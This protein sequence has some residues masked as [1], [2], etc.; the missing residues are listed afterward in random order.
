MFAAPILEYGRVQ[1]SRDRL[2]PAFGPNDGAHAT[3][4]VLR[5]RPFDVIP[6]DFYLYV[7]RAKRI[8]DR[9]FV[10]DLLWS[11]N[12]SAPR[13]VASVPFQAALGY[14]AY[15]TKGEPAVYAAFLAAL[16]FLSW[17][18]SALI[19][20]ANSHRD[21]N[22]TGLLLASLLAFI[23]QR[24]SVIA[25]LFRSLWETIVTGSFLTGPIWQGYNIWPY[26][27]V[28]RFST[29]AWSL[30]LLLAVNATAG[31]VVIAPA[32][33]K[34]L[35]TLFGCLVL[36]ALGDSWSL[37]MATVVVGLAAGFAALRA[38]ARAKGL[39][40]RLHASVMESRAGILIG[41]AAAA[42]ALFGLMPGPTGDAMIRA[43]VGSWWR[44]G[45]QPS[46]PILHK[47]WMADGL[48]WAALACIVCS[49]VAWWVR[50]RPAMLG[51]IF[52][53]LMPVAAGLILI[54]G[55]Y[56]IGL[57]PWQAHHFVDRALNG[58]LF[59]LFLVLVLA[60]QRLLTT[61]A[62]RPSE[63]RRRM[64]YVTGLATALLL[65]FWSVHTVR[66]HRVVTEGMHV[67]DYALPKDF[68]RLRDGLVSVERALPAER[69]LTLA[70]LSHEINY[71]A[72]ASTNFDLVLPE[73]FPLQ[74]AGSD[75]EI[76][77]RTSNLLR[78][79]GATEATWRKFEL[80]HHPDDQE[81]WLDS[82]L[83]S[84]RQGY[85][86]YLYHREGG[87]WLLGERRKGVALLKERLHADNHSARISPDLVV[88]DETSSFFGR[89][90]LS[91]YTKIVCSGHVELWLRQ[92][93]AGRLRRAG[94]LQ[95]L[96]G[97]VACVSPS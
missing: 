39:R 63:A 52:T 47:Y 78:F 58:M 2:Q 27:Q 53:A 16:V 93:L 33:R 71:I 75:E 36:L 6:E 76:A 90:D 18:V 12:A 86:Y 70:T 45:I 29:H 38:G 26:G 80:D 89:P 81:S 14:L 32:G 60:G 35:V 77:I 68:E 88:I 55:L 25:S 44:I 95:R 54:T 4:F 40:A 62:R 11:G 28:L 49:A 57:E 17:T 48:I 10:G 43:G 23:C 87:Q 83:T 22:R 5:A 64:T 79:Y 61:G 96:T 24:P 59:G 56:G 72:A 42:A 20:Q 31:M 51:A 1:A 97:T 13:V 65:A 21:I 84:E 91:Q 8:A 41:E 74:N 73:G 46:S 50:P 67:E 15:L 34:A 66:I 37:M 92:D 69:P 3:Y 94:L 9:G 19:I 7:V 85:Y 30:P 82:R